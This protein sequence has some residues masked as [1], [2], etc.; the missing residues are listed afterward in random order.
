MHVDFHLSPEQAG[1][2]PQD[3]PRMVAVRQ[4]FERPLEAD[5]PAAVKR[6]MQGFLPQVKAGMRIAVTGSSRGIA[7][8][9]SLIKGV[10]DA[11]KA[12]GGVPFV[13]PGMGSHGGA[14][15]QGQIDVLTTA[16]ITEKSMGVP[17]CSSM[18]VVWI[19][20]TA[21]GFPVYQDKIASEADAVFVVN[22]VK[23]HTIFTGPVESGI[24]K[25]IV[26]GLG[27]QEGASRIHQQAL[28]V[29]LGKM[30]QDATEIILASPKITF[31]GALAVVENA[32]KETAVVKA[33]P[34]HSHQA[35]LA[36]EGALLKQS[37]ALLPRI[38][39][40]D[41]DAL[42]VDEMGKNISGSGMDT[43]IT[44]RKQG[45]SRPCI[46]AIFIR[47]LTQDTH[48]NATGIGMADVMHRRLLDEIDFNATY[49]NAFTAKRL[50]AAKLPFLVDSEAQAIQVL[51]NFRQ[52]ADPSSIRMVWIRNTSQLE[53]LW[54]SECMRTE[55]ATNPSL[56]VAGEGVA[57]KVDAQGDLISC[58]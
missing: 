58:W 43:N 19:G 30:V 55:V 53:R 42:V 11:L 4:R 57:L 49:M 36:E 34:M 31:L 25:M 40:D 14:S 32:F 18:E 15:A 16:G 52:E 48:G 56:S 46:A 24:C 6:E 54:V 3:F 9:A 2:T 44:A 20:E 41:I 38:P 51:M 39:F 17:I 33:V 35:L 7:N 50:F 1:V 22:R 26:I 29:D 5:I 45:M 13:V 27:K 12:A 10:V 23:P 28:K 47:G 37:Y 8:L 21:T